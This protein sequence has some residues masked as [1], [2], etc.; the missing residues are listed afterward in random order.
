MIH[1]NN[2]NTA[3]DGTI[4]VRIG[5]FNNE[6]SGH[7]VAPGITV[8][9]LLQKA[10]IVLMNNESIFCNAVKCEDGDV[11]EDGDLLQI[12]GAKQGGNEDA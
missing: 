3:S 11:L 4:H 12:V 7:D 1:N 6:V 10:S 2:D 8:A 5:R 9:D